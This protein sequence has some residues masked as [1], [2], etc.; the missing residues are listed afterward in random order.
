M[1]KRRARVTLG[2]ARVRKFLESDPE[3]TPILAL[4][5][6]KGSEKSTF[7]KTFLLTSKI[8]LYHINSIATIYSYILTIIEN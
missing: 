3:S 7:L 4:I 5:G 2:Q 6:S 8:E 1:T